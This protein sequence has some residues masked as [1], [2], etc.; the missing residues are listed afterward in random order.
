MPD[1][2]PCGSRSSFDDCC[3]PLL[4]ATALADTAEQLMR[5]RYT[6]NFYGNAEH[7]WR[8][9]HPRTRPQ[10]VTLDQ[11]MKWTG[12]RI[13]EVDGGGPGDQ[14]GI[15]SFVASYEGGS[16]HE[17]SIFERRGGRW[18]YLDEE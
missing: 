2:C 11:G 6:A 3:G 17:R 4:G 18:L 13:L 1:P 7:L 5:S 14:R 15:V 12:L 8:T 9:W 16:M 10:Q